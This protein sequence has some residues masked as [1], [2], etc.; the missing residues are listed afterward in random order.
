LELFIGKASGGLD[1]AA[2]GGGPYCQGLVSHT[3][4]DELGQC[5]CVLHVKQERDDGGT[6]SPRNERGASPPILPS[7]LYCDSPCYLLGTPDEGVPV[8]SRCFEV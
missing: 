3:G 8:I 7:R 6:C 4:L 5:F 1:C 2:E